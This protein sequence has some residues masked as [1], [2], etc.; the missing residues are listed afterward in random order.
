MTPDQRRGFL[1]SPEFLNQLTAGQLKYIERTRDL[2]AALEAAKQA[3]SDHESS[4]VHAWVPTREYVS[5]D[6]Y[7]RAYTIIRRECPL[8]G[9]SLDMSTENHSNYG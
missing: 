1:N 6:Y 7:N 9:A 3:L 8:C 5:G 4:C 2:Q